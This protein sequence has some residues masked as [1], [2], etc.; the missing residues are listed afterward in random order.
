MTPCFHRTDPPL[1]DVIDAL[2]VLRKAL[3]VQ[4]QFWAYFS[5]DIF[6][7]ESWSIVLTIF[8]PV[9][10]RRNDTKKIC[11]QSTQ[12]PIGPH[13]WHFSSRESE[14]ALQVPVGLMNIALRLRCQSYQVKKHTTA[15]D[16]ALHYDLSVRWI[17]GNPKKTVVGGTFLDCA[18]RFLTRC[19]VRCAFLGICS[20]HGHASYLTLSIRLPLDS[21]FCR[22][23]GMLVFMLHF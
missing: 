14:L 12:C 4:L 6:H 10:K 11:K 2:T 22:S 15:W 3:L 8:E 9:E 7:W 1:L 19:G 17:G 16:L 5:F 13:V 21:Q 20:S 23:T 18:L